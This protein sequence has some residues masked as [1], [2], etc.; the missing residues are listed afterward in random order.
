MT[1]SAVWIIGRREPLAV[2]RGN[3]ERRKTVVSPSAG[4]CWEPG[5]AAAFPGGFKQHILVPT[6]DITDILPNCQNP[7]GPH[8][9]LLPNQPR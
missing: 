8:T 9:L 7:S 4:A 2:Q 1:N 5:S 6:Q 3:A